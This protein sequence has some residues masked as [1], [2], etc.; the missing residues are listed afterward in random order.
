MT[1]A[2]PFSAETRRRRRLVLL[3]IVAVF[4]LP[5]LAARWYYAS[6]AERGGPAVTT[7]HGVLVD[8]ARPLPTVFLTPLAET[9]LPDTVLANKWT[10]LMV[11]DNGC[12]KTCWE[13]LYKTRQIRTALNQEMSRVQRL[14]ILTGE[15]PLE[16]PQEL[17]AQHPALMI[18]QA[19][20]SDFGKLLSQLRIAGEPGPLKADRI[21]LV[22][23]LGNLLMWY[24]PGQSG[25]DMLHDLQKLLKISQIG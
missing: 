6:I 8:P 14:L 22:D 10:L 3:A 21:Y 5:I 15:V 18:T 4:L 23:P 17:R 1:D 25:T 9:E 2:Q 7:N 24:P 13:N 12:D 20:A 19:R 16:L 11:G